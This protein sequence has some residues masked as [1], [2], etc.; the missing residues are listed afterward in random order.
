MLPIPLCRE[1]FSNADALFGLLTDFVIYHIPHI[2]KTTCTNTKNNES[3]GHVTLFK[4]TIYIV[5]YSISRAGFVEYTLYRGV[6]ITHYS[7]ET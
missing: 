4:Y 7:P 5:C 2:P 6:F 3:Q 1:K